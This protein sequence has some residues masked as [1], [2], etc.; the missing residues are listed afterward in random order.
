MD[1]VPFSFSL[2]SSK[3]TVIEENGQTHQLNEVILNGDWL[4]SSIKSGS[5]VLLLCQNNFESVFFYVN[6]VERGVATILLDSDI[7]EGLLKALIDEYKP[8]FVFCPSSTT[9]LFSDYSRERDY[10]NYCLYSRQHDDE[11]HVNTELAVLLSTSGTTG[12]PKLVRLSKFNLRSNAESICNYLCID[13]SYRAITNLPMNYSFGL[14]IV[15]S[16]L[17]A[18]GAIVVTNES[19][20]QRRFWSLFNEHKV[21][22]FS[23]VPFT[24][25]IL[26]KL[27]LLNAEL[28][29]LKMLT[30]A[31]GKL[32]N[33]LIEF[34][35]QFSRGKGVEFFVMYGQTE[36]TARL[37]YLHPHYTIEKLGSI[38]KPIPNG[39]FYII[40]GY[41][42]KI[43]E[44]RT[45][46]EL[47][48][49][50][51]NVMLGYAESRAD[52]YLGDVNRGRL[53]TGDIAFCDDDGY[54]FIVGRIKRFIKLFGNRVNLDELESLLFD[55]GVQAACVG[56]D[57]FL[58][59]YITNLDNK[60]I[61]KEFLAKKLAIHFSV[62][63]IRLISKIPKSSS[64]KTL[65]SN[66]S[67]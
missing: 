1:I 7:N 15:N 44:P 43:N 52:L 12:S 6:A 16:H 2:F 14:S 20:T 58:V 22:S 24:F 25:E 36:G 40:D 8:K 41:G 59:I 45:P 56:R 31:G 60:D 55:I 47:V 26:K 46:G 27:R 67:L 64:G 19:I 65:Y 30:Q 57:N 54:Y 23:G 63:D 39:E 29:S 33:E 11:F 42:N 32:S 17:F 61:V 37:S 51:P 66:L 62:V 35:A 5:L 21:T 34:F 9:Y 48:Y 4:F 28:P 49:S 13:S 53:L 50:G 18:G 3:A 10:R 38:G